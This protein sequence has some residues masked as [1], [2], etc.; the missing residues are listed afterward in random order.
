MPSYS[1]PVVPMRRP[2]LVSVVLAAVAC[3]TQATGTS[4]GDAAPAAPDGG[5]DATSSQPGCPSAQP[6]NGAACEPVNAYCG[7]SGSPNPCGA[8]NCYCESTG[9]SCVPTCV[10]DASTDAVGDASDAGGDGGPAQAIAIPMYVDPTASPALWSQANDAGA[11]VA[12]LVANPDS[13]PGTSA[14]AEYTQAIAATHAAGQAIVGYVHTSYGSRALSDVEADVDSWYSFYP[15]I[16]GIFVDETSTDVSTVA[17]YYQPLDAYVKAKTG[18]P[19]TV[20]IN[21]GT[22]VDE[23]FMQAA[24]IVVTFEDTYANYTNGTYPANPAWAASYPRWRFWHLVLSAATPAEMQNAV[25]IARD[26]NVGYVYVTDQG[27]ST[28]YQQIITG[29]YWQAELAAVGEP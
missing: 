13:G 27:P 3:G 20:V 28:A 18:G 15:A 16:D 7:Y 4:P 25:S 9:W 24:D 29:A 11:A 5:T 22:I 17:S 26:R 8:V 2:L 19:R 14:E 1:D 6:A 10:Y 21:P 23:S 12:L